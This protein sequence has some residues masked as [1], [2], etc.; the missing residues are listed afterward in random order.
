MGE[1]CAIC[2]RHIEW[3][4]HTESA[5]LK[6]RVA[7]LEAEVRRLEQNVRDQQ[8]DKHDLYADIASL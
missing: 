8:R 1:F 4:G 7:E 6:A 5:H 3:D 2:E